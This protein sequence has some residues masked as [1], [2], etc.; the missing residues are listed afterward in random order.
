M[1]LLL[2]V[3]LI[4]NQSFQDL[5]NMPKAS[6]VDVY[7]VPL[8]EANEQTLQGYGH[9]V[10]DYDKE[11]VILETWPASGWRPVVS[12][13]GNQGGIHEGDFII[14]REGDR[15]YAE[16]QAVKAKYM[17]GI[18]EENSTYILTHEANYHPDGGQVFFPKDRA[19]FIVLLAKPGDNIQPQS[20]TA[21]YFDGSFG[22]QIN[23]GVWHQPPFP[24]KDEVC[25]QDKQGAVHACIGCDF[26]KEF[27]CYLAIPTSLR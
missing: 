2:L 3:T 19:P 12:G 26:I 10:Y 17:T 22:V 8:V 16:N 6:Q 15:I 20:F 11:D 27:G 23:P 1:L 13:T 21:F 7:H 25:L 4:H 9:L 18:I 24:A 5:N 14:R